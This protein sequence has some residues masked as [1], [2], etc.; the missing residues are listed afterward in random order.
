MF[1]LDPDEAIYVIHALPL[2]EREKKSFRR[3][4]KR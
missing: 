2:T 4:R 1:V 3:R